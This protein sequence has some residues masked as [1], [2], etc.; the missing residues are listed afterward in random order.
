V[1]LCWC[2]SQGA[3]ADSATTELRIA[4]GLLRSQAAELELLR[5]ESRHAGLPERTVRGHAMQLERE[6]QRAREQLDKAPA[7][8]SAAPVR[9][10]AQAA[11]QQLAVLVSRL[12]DT[13]VTDSSFD[14]LASLREALQQHEA[15]LPH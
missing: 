12:A 15:A 4:V 7:P 8:A 3:L 10:E 14:T 13:G 2:C 6:V 9:A 11:G 1:L 5:H